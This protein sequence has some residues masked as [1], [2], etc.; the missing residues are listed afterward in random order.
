MSGSGEFLLR[1]LKVW[2]VCVCFYDIFFIFRFFVFIGVCM[3]RFCVCC[4][5]YFIIVR[6]LVFDIKDKISKYC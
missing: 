2:L 4:V 6:Y 5:Y 3:G 1:E